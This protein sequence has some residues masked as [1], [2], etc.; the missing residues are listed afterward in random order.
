VASIPLNG[1][2]QCKG[3]KKNP[4]RLAYSKSIKFRAA[5]ESTNAMTEYDD[6]EQI[7][8]YDYCDFSL[9][10]TD[11]CKN[12]QVFAGG[13]FLA[14][15]RFIIWTQDGH[16]Y[17]YQLLNSGLSKSVYPVDGGLLK[18]TITPHLLCST[19]VIEESSSCTMGF[20][21]ERKEPFFKI[22][23]SGD[24]TGQLRFWHIPDVPVTQFDGSP[25]GKI[26]CIFCYFKIKNMYK[27]S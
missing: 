27:K 10:C 15:N 24:S 23:Y 6:K 1:I 22:L 5:P 11:V 26:Y 7:K 19:R 2:G 3:S 13:E 18:E 20:V 21:N 16:S 14:A 9:F 8:V 4:Q 17:I 12:G 25:L